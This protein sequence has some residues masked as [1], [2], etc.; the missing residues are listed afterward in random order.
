MAV[1]TQ[2]V[3]ENRQTDASTATVRLV[4]TAVSPADASGCVAQ[5]GSYTLG[6]AYSG[7]TNVPNATL[8]S[9]N[10]SP[11]DGSAGAT[12][13]ATVFYSNAVESSS[14][15]TSSG[16]SDPADNYSKHE[17]S[18]VVEFVD[19]WR[20]VS[21]LSG[22]N[23]STPTETDIAGTAIDAAGVPV[24][25]MRRK[26]EMTFTVRLAS[27]SIDKTTILGLIGKR[28]S[29]TFLG[30]AAG[31]VLFHGY[32][33]SRVGPNLYDVT[34]VFTWDEWA[35]LRQVPARDA[36]QL[37]KREGTAGYAEK[38]YPVYWKQPF[39]STGNF[40]TLPGY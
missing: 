13:E 2:S 30:G 18:V 28:N 19:A 25:V 35:H 38:A 36:D 34:Y 14:G 17:A 3:E 22:V 37:P 23:L 31:Y 6:S 12:W 15:T 8:R 27:G 1:I 39:P 10:Y 9:L 26:Q 5:L 16:G 40:S 24:S 32:R 33:Q 29:A 7:S 20:T 4:I 11:I 21:S